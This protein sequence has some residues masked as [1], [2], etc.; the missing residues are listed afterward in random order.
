MKTLYFEDIKNKQHDASGV[1]N[2]WKHVWEK[3]IT[4][5]HYPKAEHKKQ[6]TYYLFTS[7][8]MVE[9]YESEGINVFIEECKLQKQTFDKLAFIHGVTHPNYLLL[10]NSGFVSY[11]V[12]SEQDFLKL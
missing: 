7:E 2:P 11:C 4:G 3:A 5:M 1:S 12:M 6:I 8:D 10:V 9:L